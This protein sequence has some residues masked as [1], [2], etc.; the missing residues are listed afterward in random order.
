VL[1]PFTP[2]QLHQP[3]AVSATR[4]HRDPSHR[5]AVSY[6][7]R[8][9]AC[10]SVVHGNLDGQRV[11]TGDLPV[12]LKETDMSE[13]A[14]D[15]QPRFAEVVHTQEQLTELFE[16]KAHTWRYAGFVSV[17]VQRRAALQPRLRDHLLAYARPTGERAR[18][19]VEV[20]QFVIDSMHDLGQIAEQL[21]SFMRSPAFVAI[22][23]E[24]H[25]EA[26]ADA[27]SVMQTA[28]RLIDYYE[29]FLALSERARGL[30]APADYAELLNNCAR[31]ADTG[32]DAFH[33]FI[34]EFVARVAAMPALLIAADGAD[35]KGEP[36]VLHIEA[37]DE[38]LET[39]VQQLRTIADDAAYT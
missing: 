32:L 15:D 37:D 1:K 2:Q 38:L 9:G 22:V 23:C 7:R 5:I 34:D 28:M 29:R 11:A 31:L 25:D 19:G 20:A 8:G 24:P 39:I 14:D 35:I 17:L 21:T 30:A 4:R 18:D 3:Q 13:A 16:E 33:N 10:L 26:T 27:Q 6:T 36:V 12:P